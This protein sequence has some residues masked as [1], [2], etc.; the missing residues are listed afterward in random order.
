M[1]GDDHGWWRRLIFSPL[2]GLLAG[3][4]PIPR[5][6]EL[7]RTTAAFMATVLRTY[8]V[9]VLQLQPCA[10]QHMA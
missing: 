7:L 6:S 9:T 1:G 3:A 10:D 5:G 8:G 2:S 4:A